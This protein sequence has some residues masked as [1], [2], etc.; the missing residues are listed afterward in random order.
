MRKEEQDIKYFAVNGS[1]QELIKMLKQHAS[2]V[3][4]ISSEA[5]DRHNYA[6]TK[7][8]SCSLGF[9]YTEPAFAPNQLTGNVNALKEQKMSKEEKIQSKDWVVMAVMA[10]QP[11]IRFDA[12]GSKKSQWRY[13]PLMF[14]APGAKKVIMN[15]HKGDSIMVEGR[16]EAMPG[17]DPGNAMSFKC[18]MLVESFLCNASQSARKKAEAK[19]EKS[20]ERSKG[21]GEIENVLNDSSLSSDKKIALIQQM[22]ASNKQT[23]KKSM[24]DAQS[25]DSSSLK[26]SKSRGKSK[27]PTPVPPSE[28]FVQQ[29]LSNKSSGKPVQVN[30]K[31]MTF[32]GNISFS[33]GENKTSKNSEQDDHKS[34]HYACQGY[35][36]DD[37]STAEESNES[38]D[39]FAS[40]FDKWVQQIKLK[41]EQGLLVPEFNDE[42]QDKD[43]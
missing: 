42:D 36:R 12:N 15:Y 8:G 41:D 40:S 29:T 39:E 21:L 43:K 25:E 20:E 10:Y 9:L 19:F 5:F 34:R 7:S 24:Q 22:M 35:K 18:C 2:S 17:E 27:Q 37:V 1:D 38:E 26:R 31:D 14:A 4:T 6:Y 3:S 23:A 13:M 16:L 30:G 33:N 11:H 28:I 32:E